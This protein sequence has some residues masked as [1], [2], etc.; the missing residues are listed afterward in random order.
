MPKFRSFRTPL[1]FFGL[2]FCL[3]PI[4]LLAE[5]ES[6]RL[7]FQLDNDLFTGSD[8]NYTSGVRLARTQDLDPDQASH[9]WLQ[10]A[11][12]R[13]SGVD[14]DA[15]LG[16]FRYQPDGSDRF[17]WGMG[18][19]QLM[20]TPDDPTAE[21]APDGERP[22]AGWLGLEFSLHIKNSKSASSVTLSLGTTGENSYAD[23][24]QKW[25][26]VNV[27]NS[28]IYQGWKSQVPGETTLNLHIDH[29]QRI[30]WLSA[31]DD[32]PLEIG[33]Y[34]EW[35]AALGNLRTDA[36]AGALLRAGYNLPA[37]YTTPRVQIGSYGHALF[38]KEDQDRSP[39]SIFCFAGIRGTAVLHDI[40]LDGPVFRDFDT[41]V[42][43]EPF[44]GEILVGI[45]L[46]WDQCELSFSRTF[47]TNEFEDQ[48]KNQQF[49]SVRL[50]FKRPF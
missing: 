12:Y 5:A 35:G 10:K 46:G 25:I 3:L 24:A 22:Y 26:H 37:V 20:Y 15:F 31:T 23:D 4:T 11:L 47:R 13:F 6:P 34:T 18:L 41:G 42:N 9:N 16:R 40:T 45:G 32:W 19:T 21:T 14:D 28:P 1:P 50:R 36:Y 29:K 8:R 27:S 39:F 30:D 44:V 7:L 49:G 43:R 38:Q 17:S 48:D 2:L 33:G